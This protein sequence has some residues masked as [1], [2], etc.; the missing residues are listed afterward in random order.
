MGGLDFVEEIL[1][2]AMPAAG[3][4]L[5]GVGFGEEWLLH[6]VGMD[7]VVYLL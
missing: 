1:S 2:E 7:A 5:L 6:S 4:L 3:L